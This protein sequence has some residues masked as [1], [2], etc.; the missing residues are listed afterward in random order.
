MKTTFKVLGIDLAS[1]KWQDNGSAM[2]TFTTGDDAA[3]CAVECGCIEWPIHDHLSSN[4]MADVIEQ[5][6]KEH[7]ISAVSLDGPQ[8][9]RQPNAPERLG[10][11]RVC[12]YEASCQ[13]KTGT[14]GRTYPQ[15]QHGWIKFCID[16]FAELM[17]RGYAQIVNSMEGVDTDLEPDGYWLLE[18]FPTST[19]RESR[20]P[21]LPGKSRVG[22]DMKLVAVYWR[23]LQQRFGLPQIASSTFTHDDLQAIVAALPAA[24]LMKGPCL[25]IPKGKPGWWERATELHPM[26][27][28]ESIIWDATLTEDVLARQIEIPAWVRENPRKQRQNASRNPLLIDDRDDAGDSLIDR[29]VKLFRHLAKC[30]N[31]GNA[32]GISYAQLVCFVHGVEQFQEVTNRRYAQSDTQNVLCFAE[33]ITDIAGGPIAISKNG[34]TIRAGMDAFVWQ[35]RTPHARPAAAFA[36]A[37]YSQKEWT[38]VFPDGQRILLTTDEFSSILNP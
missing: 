7:G 10:V 9:W 27:W 17:D 1:R 29:G 8:G 33:Q 22:N 18:C 21:Q 34:V 20:L 38:D 30:A 23:I 32:I 16:V 26:H 15:T 14:Y 5:T 36:T 31:N 37:G 6:V 3:W 13:G 2:I 12:E 4:A 11:G 24:G 25:A 19:W 35:K 28:V